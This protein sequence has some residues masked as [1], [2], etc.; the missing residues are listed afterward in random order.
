MTAGIYIKNESGDIQIDGESS[1]MYMV[2]KATY[3]AS[4]LEYTCKSPLSIVAIYLHDNVNTRMR[5]D[6]VDNLPIGDIRKYSIEIVNTNHNLTEGT[7]TVY[8]FMNIGNAAIG[9]I[10]GKSGLEIYNENGNMIYSSNYPTLNVVS[11]LQAIYMDNGGALPKTN[12]I[13]THT[14]PIRGGTSG[15]KIATVITQLGYQ[16][17]ST[18][19]NGEFGL[20]FAIPAFWI[21]VSQGTLNLQLQWLKIARDSGSS[22]L[23]A[24]LVNCVAMAIDVTNY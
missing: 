4:T 12:P 5:C 19:I 10:T 9:E 20:W 22:T 21:D 7:F 11:Y 13:A 14:S 24:G 2:N 6:L 1:A 17:Q 3:T 23:P 18:Y 8:E 15:K 16:G